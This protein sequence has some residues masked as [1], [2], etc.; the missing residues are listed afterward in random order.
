MTV[1]KENIILLFTSIL[2]VLINILGIWKKTKLITSHKD[3]ILEGDEV[4]A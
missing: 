2:Q 3:L 4:E 1:K